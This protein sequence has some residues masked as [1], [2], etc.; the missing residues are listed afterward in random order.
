MTSMNSNNKHNAT[1]VAAVSFIVGTAFASLASY[2]ISSKRKNQIISPS[3]TSSKTISIPP[4]MRSEQLSRNELFFG[5]DGMKTIQNASVLVVGLGGVGSHTAHMLGRAG[6]GYLRLVDFDQVTLSSLNRH[7]CATLEDVGIPKVECMKRF[8]YRICGEHCVIDTRSQMY[9]G[10]AAKDGDMMTCP[11][12]QKWD[13]VIDA[14]DDVPTKAKLVAHCARNNI[15]VLCCMGAGGKSD[16]TRLHISDLRTASRDPLASKL[17]M[18]L[19]GLMKHD[20]SI[21]DSSCLEDVDKVAV[22]WSSEKVVAKLADFTEE[23]K[24]QGVHKFGAVDNMRIRVLPVLG[25]M[26]AIMGQGLAAMALCEMGGKPFTPTCGERVGRNVRHKLLQR[27]KQRENDLRTKFEKDADPL[28][29]EELDEDGA[30]PPRVIDGKWVGP[31]QIDTDDVEYILQEVWRNRCCIS[32]ASL[33]TVL[34]IVRWDLSKPSNCQNIVVLGAKA[35]VVYEKA[36]DE[37]GDG[38]SGFPLDARS[39]IESR[40]STCMVDS[41]A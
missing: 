6:V 25:T 13:I 7:A 34:H 38:R 30:R 5:S 4:E 26:P 14:I 16:M 27:M 31:I 10:D 3:S 2:L 21:A 18:T 11:N 8:L 40:L 37:T 32:G 41:R 29:N 15:R 12:G 28:E 36:L 19:R 1:T 35:L 17:R 33:G 23:Q 24:E 20:N 9:T 39:R 22:M